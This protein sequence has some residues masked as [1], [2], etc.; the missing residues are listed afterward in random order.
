MEAWEGHS[1]H[2]G[3]SGSA[4]KTWPPGHPPRAGLWARECLPGGAGGR[5]RVPA[6]KDR[7]GERAKREETPV[8]ACC[9]P[10]AA[11]S[12]RPSPGPHVAAQPGF[13]GGPRRTE[14]VCGKPT[15]QDN[16]LPGRATLLL[17]PR[18]LGRRQPRGRPLVPAAI[19]NALAAMISSR[20]L[21]LPGCCGCFAI[22]QELKIQLRGRRMPTRVGSAPGGAARGC[23]RLQ[24]PVGSSR[25]GEQSQL[26]GAGRPESPPSDTATHRKSL[27]THS[28]TAQ[29]TGAGQAATFHAERGENWTHPTPPDPAPGAAVSETFGSLRWEK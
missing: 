14:R 2:R 7:E 6:T 21:L 4:E 19:R 26:R 27:D 20:P 24:C 10:P 25:D 23:W 15:L 18:P 17:T 5:P 16:C 8:P 3:A 1:R 13:P 29:H 11:A 12:P 28:Q 9:R 22:W